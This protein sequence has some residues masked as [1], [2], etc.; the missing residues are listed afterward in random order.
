VR[1]DYHPALREATRRSV[2]ADAFPTDWEFPRLTEK[3]RCDLAIVG[4]GFTGLWAAILA[5]QRQPERD[6]VVIEAETIGH[7]ASSRNGGFISASLTHGH[8]HGEA[9]WPGEMETLVE[10]GRQNYSQIRAFIGEHEIDSD[11]SDCGKTALAVS[12]VQERS[13]P[14]VFAVNQRHGEEV[15]LLSAEEVQ[16][17]VASPTYRGGVRVRTGSGLFHPVKLIVGM[18]AVAQSLGIRF[19]QHSPI[20]SMNASG[21][22]VELRSTRGAIAAHRVVLAT[23]AFSP[24]L[25]GIRARV[26]PLFDHVVATEVLSPAQLDSLGWRESQG[27][28]DLGNQFHY[29]RKTPDNRIL[30]GGYDA[31]YYFGNDTSVERE[32]RE[33]SHA[34]LAH[35][36]F[37]T[38][39]QL[40]GVRFEYQWAGVIDSTSRFT[41][42]FS[43][44]LG[45]RV[46]SALGFTGLGTGS[47]RMGAMIALDLLEDP[48]STLLTLE[49]VRRKP[50]P[51]PPEPVRFPLV[52]FTK[53]SLA[54]EDLAGRRNLWLKMLDLLK[55]GFNS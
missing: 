42:Y 9:M 53:W 50:I 27:L 19:V 3:T 33:A 55:V 37:D 15:Q 36:F 12:A 1:G 8:A 14:S 24:L 48:R 45:G 54:R 17:D 21:L 31:N 51:F 34:L 35:H 25:P 20:T 29:Y 2:W 40:E 13:L 39:P 7:A 49:M 28:T 44:A 26:L 23:S 16:A 18:V 43:R 47:S 4:S 6:V 11:W 10:L 30:F 5:K 22:G 41:P 46:A 38:F 32:I 52:Q